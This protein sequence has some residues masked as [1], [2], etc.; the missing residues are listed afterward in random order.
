MNYFSLDAID[1]ILE[2]TW[3]NFDNGYFIE[4]GANDG[5]CQS[6]TLYFE[7]YRG[8]KGI[9]VEPILH[10]FFTCKA[11]RRASKVFCNAC[12]SFDYK[13]PCVELWYSNLMTSSLGVETE[14]DPLAQAQLGNKFLSDVE[15]VVRTASIAITLDELMQRAS[16]PKYIDFLSIDVE[17]AEAEVIN[18]INFYTYRFGVLCIESRE[19]EKIISLVSPFGYKY[20]QSIGQNVIMAHRDAKPSQSKDDPLVVF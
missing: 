6:N 4:L 15:E 1:Q 17:G 2:S 18:G 11:N 19:P 12:V 5:I 7:R 13:L 20:I 14:L 16:S 10:K 3:L 8:W 9:L